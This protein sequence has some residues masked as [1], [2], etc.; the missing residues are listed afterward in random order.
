MGCSLTNLDLP[1][2]MVLSLKEAE[3]LELWDSELPANR[4]APIKVGISGLSNFKMA[5]IF[6]FRS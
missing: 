2:S 4:Q 3:L 1:L 6:D 5:Q